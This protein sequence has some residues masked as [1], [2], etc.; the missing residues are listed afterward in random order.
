MRSHEWEPSY[1]TPEER[2]EELQQ[3]LARLSIDHQRPSD[4]RILEIDGRA[5]E[6][7]R[8]GYR[9]QHPVFLL[10]GSPGHASDPIPRNSRPHMLGVSILSYS[11]P[12]YGASDRHEGRTVR[13]EVAR[14][15]AI[16]DAYNIR[17]FSVIGRSGGGPSALAAAS[18][19]PDRVSSVAVLAGPAPRAAEPVADWTAGMSEENSQLHRHAA[20]DR[21]LLVGEIAALAAQTQTDP[22]C[23]LEYLRP[24]FADS[25]TLATSTPLLY[26]FLLQ[27][28]RNGLLDGEHGWVD[29]VLALHDDWGFDLQE[30]T[31]PTL[32]W[33]PD[34]DPFTPPEHGQ[35]LYDKIPNAELVIAPDQSH[36]ESFYFIEHA[37]AW[38]RDNARR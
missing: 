30:T 12:G 3:R 1:H 25:D 14:I 8:F 10:H 36:F 17:R 2:R 4:I 19:L 7:H 18:L 37:L 31:M 27:A 9:D 32:L 28:Y 11:R 35:R 38:C 24:Q 23:L 26:P 29:D 6:T 13:D 22:A 21:Q 16:A 33:Y 20:A 15:E 34:K 5:V